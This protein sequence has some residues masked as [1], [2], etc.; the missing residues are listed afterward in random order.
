MAVHVLF[1]RSRSLGFGTVIIYN[2]ARVTYYELFDKS[3]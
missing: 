3:N 1:I 2:S